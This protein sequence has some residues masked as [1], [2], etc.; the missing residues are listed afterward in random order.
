MGPMMRSLSAS[1]KIA[2]G[3]MPLVTAD[4]SN[5]QAIW[6]T[7]DGKGPSI[8]WSILHM[9]HYRY[10]IMG[11]LGAGRPDPFKEL[12]SKTADDGKN[13][14]RIDDLAKR[15]T[16]VQGEFSAVLETVTDEAL[17]KLVPG[18]PH[19]ETQLLDTIAFFAWHEAYHMGVIGQLRKAQGLLGPAEK[20]MAAKERA[21]SSHR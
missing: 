9:L 16:A 21:A 14:P 8:S 5:E 10:N 15:W 1:F 13:Y 12:G 18:G 3:L 6:R 7:R 2:D 19:G 4:L 11:A 20:V 17:K